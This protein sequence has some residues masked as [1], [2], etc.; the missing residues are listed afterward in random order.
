M[1]E[2]LQMLFDYPPFQFLST[3]AVIPDNFFFWPKEGYRLE[4]RDGSDSLIAAVSREKTFE[5]FLRLMEQF[6][7]ELDV[8]MVSRAGKKHD[9]RP[10]RLWATEKDPIV[11]MSALRQYEEFLMND[12]NVGISLLNS[13]DHEDTDLQLDDHK[14]LCAFRRP[15]KTQE[16]L[17]REGIRRNDQLCVV[18]DIGH[19]HNPNANEDLDAFA[20][21]AATLGAEEEQTIHTLDTEGGDDDVDWSTA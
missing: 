12:G 9:E 11:V 6:P 16:I 5:I 13:Q 8:V 10:L 2:R 17:E 7:G 19:T 21:L 18:S 3:Q 20:H 15:R 1:D 4:R 14:I